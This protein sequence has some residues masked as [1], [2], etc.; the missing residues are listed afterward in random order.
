MRKFLQR[1]A[2]PLITGLFLVSLISGV[3]LFFHVGPTGFHAMHEWLS[4][5]L[6][7]PFALHLWKNWKPLTAYLRKA[8]MGIALAASAVAA[9]AFFYPATG[10]VGREA[11]G[12]PQF[13]LARQVLASPVTA[14]APVLGTTPDALVDKLTASGFTVASADQTLSDI[15]KASGKSE[16]ELAGTLM[17][18]GS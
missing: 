8:A 3:A 7:V 18:K 1:Y 14:V 15:A 9:L 17:K 10:T 4:M 2:T 5:V 11:G 16:V 13:A 6:I 12:P